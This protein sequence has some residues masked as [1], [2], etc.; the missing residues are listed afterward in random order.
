MKKVA[1]ATVAFVVCAAFN[2]SAFGDAASCE[3]CRVDAHAKVVACV[4]KLGPEVKPADPKHPTQAEKDAANK[5]GKA[6][7]A[8]AK[9]ANDLNQACNNGECKK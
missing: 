1:F 9:L 7:S 3:K 4:S 2:A 6:E 8:C 5:R